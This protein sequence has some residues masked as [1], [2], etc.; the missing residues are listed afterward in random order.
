MKGH[1]CPHI[2]LDPMLRLHSWNVGALSQALGY[3]PRTF[4]RLVECSVGMPAKPWL[5]RHRIV[6]ACHLL[7]EGWKIEAVSLEFGFRNPSAFSREFKSLMD[8][9]PSTFL[10]MERARF[11]MPPPAAGD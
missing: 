11:F 5:R 8:V 4:S 2:R 7:R 10:S 3:S 9:A 6:T 1:A